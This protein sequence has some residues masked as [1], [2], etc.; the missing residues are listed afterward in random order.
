MADTP[1][2]CLRY[3]DHRTWQTRPHR[4]VWRH[5]KT[6]RTGQRPAGSGISYLVFDPG[7]ENHRDAG[8]M[9][10][11]SDSALRLQ[12]PFAVYAADIWSF[13]TSYELVVAH[14]AAFD[15]RFINCEMRLSGLPALT[16]PVYCTMKGYRALELGGNASLSAVCSQIK[17]RVPAR[18]MERWRMPGSRCKSIFGCA[19]ARFSI[20]AALASS[21]CHPTGVTH[22]RP[23]PWGCAHPAFRQPS[24][25]G[26][27]RAAA[28]PTLPYHGRPESAR[29]CPRTFKKLL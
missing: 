6:A 28:H 3:R 21:A 12:N 2:L 8:R 18:R 11:F 27:P 4:K 7:T 22:D 17:L 10:G 29:G 9:H 19:A 26:Y 14:N 5:R 24:P 25:V 20:I 15:L 1:R 13:L 23:I 16:G